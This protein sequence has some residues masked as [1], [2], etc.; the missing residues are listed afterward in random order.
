MKK[1]EAVLALVSD[2]ENGRRAVITGAM[3]ARSAGASLKVLAVARRFP[4]IDAFNP[5][6]LQAEVYLDAIAGELKKRAVE[7][8]EEAGWPDA[9][10]EVARG[11]LAVSGARVAEESGS[12]LLVLGTDPGGLG[13]AAAVSGAERLLHLAHRPVL[14]TTAERSESFLR[15][16]VGVDLGRET[17]PALTAAA[18]VARI[19]GADVRVVHVHQAVPMLDELGVLDMDTVRREAEERLESLLGALEFPE[20]SRV[21]SEFRHGH[22]GPELLQAAREWEADLLVVGSHEAG[23]VERLFLGS[24]AHHVLH[25]AHI[26]TLVVPG[27]SSDP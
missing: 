2:D 9:P 10:I 22:A 14:L 16:L 23:F 13:H 5:S 11:D 20:G 26:S 15:I 1:I 12:D 6:G 18:A 19:G 27:D 3:M 7:D 4:I 8:L 17:V 25:H 24:T 21:H